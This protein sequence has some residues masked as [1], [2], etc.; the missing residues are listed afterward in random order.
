MV[1]IRLRFWATHLPPYPTV[2]PGSSSVSPPLEVNVITGVAAI[3]LAGR[4]EPRKANSRVLPK[5]L[6]EKVRPPLLAELESTYRPRP[7]RFDRSKPHPNAP[8]A[9]GSGQRFSIFSVSGWLINVIFRMPAVIS[10][11]FCVAA[12]WGSK[13]KRCMPVSSFSHLIGFIGLGSQPV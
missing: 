13:P 3:L 6:R 4:S 9:D 7:N 11:D 12:S 8:S 5:I 10:A 2:S 1:A